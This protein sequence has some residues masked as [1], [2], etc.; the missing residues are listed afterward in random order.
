MALS[1]DPSGR[2]P[3]LGMSLESMACKV[4]LKPKMIQFHYFSEKDLELTSD[5]FKT[6]TLFGS[7]H[8]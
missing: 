3:V 1:P 7:A 2:V 5:A 6:E 8:K 4:I